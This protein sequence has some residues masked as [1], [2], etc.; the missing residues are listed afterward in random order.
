MIKKLKKIKQDKQNLD[1]VAAAKKQVQEKGL[2]T[3]HGVI[4]SYTGT[5][6]DERTGEEKS[7]C[8]YI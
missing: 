5:F 7:K 2:E 1:E 6:K 8:F 3:E 4:T